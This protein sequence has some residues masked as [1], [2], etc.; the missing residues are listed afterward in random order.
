MAKTL[1]IANLGL[2]SGAVA[3]VLAGQTAQANTITGGISFSGNVTPYLSSTGSG[4][5]ATDYISAKSLV[6]GPSFVA[7]GPTQTFAGITPITTP[8]TMYSPLV[9][10]PPQLPV[11]ATSALWAVTFGGVTYSFTLSTLTEP[12]DQATFMTLTGSG[13][14]SDG[15][16]ADSNTGTWV[17]TFTTAGDT[18]SWNSSSGASGPSTPGTPD[19]GVTLMFLGLGLVLLAGYARFRPIGKQAAE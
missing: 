7:N 2:L 8:V 15:T 6:F 14:M 18:F 12:V 1:K 9:I 3:L 13:I 16:P 17:A 11:P 4:P 19:G 5:V 10:N